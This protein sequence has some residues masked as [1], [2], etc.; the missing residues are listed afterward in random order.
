MMVDP[1]G[2]P[3]TLEINR[4]IFKIITTPVTFKIGINGFQ[5]FPNQKIVFAILIIGD[6]PSRQCS[7]AEVV[8]QFFL[9]QRQ[10]LKAGTLYRN[11]FASANCSV[12]HLNTLASFTH[13]FRFSGIKDIN[14]SNNNQGENLE[15]FFSFIKS[16]KF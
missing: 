2:E 9:L 4:E 10:I 8:D 6:I 3:D 15:E 1:I 13:V 7:L 5:R 14:D 12:I 11:I 16:V